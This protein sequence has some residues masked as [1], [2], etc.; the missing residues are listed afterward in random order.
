MSR[1]I[2]DFFVAATGFFVKVTQ[3]ALKISWTIYIYY[4]VF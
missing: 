3:I 2:T 1:T 4:K